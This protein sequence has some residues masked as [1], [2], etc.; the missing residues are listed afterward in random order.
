MEDDNNT[1]SKLIEIKEILRNCEKAINEASGYNDTT[2]KLL[3][4][5]TNLQQELEEYKDAETY[6][7]KFLYKA[8]RD[9]LNANLKL[10]EENK[11]LELEN[12]QNIEM[13]NDI[14]KEQDMKLNDL[15]QAYQ[16]LKD[17][18]QWWNNRFNAVQRDYED[19]KSRIEKVQKIINTEKKLMGY[20][21]YDSCLLLIEEAIN[22]RS[23]E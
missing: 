21:I 2:D 22:G 19:Y 14:I 15:Q 11:K 4:Y 18:K 1:A 5:I 20:A 7:K 16:E 12:Q 23:N 3:D 10:V 8:N 9:R 6:S 13:L 17:S